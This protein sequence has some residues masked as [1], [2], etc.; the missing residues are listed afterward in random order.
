MEIFETKIKIPVYLDYKHN[1]DEF[2]D[3]INSISRRDINYIFSLDEFKMFFN[4]SGKT[5]AERYGIF[6]NRMLNT[7]SESDYFRDPREGE[8]FYY[9][10][11]MTSIVER[12][13]ELMVD[14][15]TI[16]STIL[17]ALSAKRCRILIYST[18]EAPTRNCIMQFIEYIIKKYP[19]IQKKNFVVLTNN[20]EL[21]YHDKINAVYDNTK[22][23]L[24]RIN[25]IDGITCIVHNVFM[26]VGHGDWQEISYDSEEFERSLRES[27]ALV[28][29]N[30]HRK[31]KF[32][33]LN[34]RP[35]PSRWMTALY[36]YP[37]RDTGLLS[38]TLDSGSAAPTHYEVFDESKFSD[39]KTEIAE[40]IKSNGPNEI[41]DSIRDF[42][43]WADFYLLQVMPYN[44]I[45]RTVLDDIFIEVK[46]RF[47]DSNFV[48][49]L[50]LLIDDSID[51][52]S[53]PVSDMA[54]DKFFDSYLHIVSETELGSGFGV[55]RADE[56]FWFTEKIFK[57][58]WFMQPFVLIGFPGSLS[59]LKTLGFKT[60]DEYIDERYDIEPNTHRRLIL[61]LH[62]A[63]QFYDRPHKE[64]LADYNDMMGILQHN[65]NLLLSYAKQI[66]EDIKTDIMNGLAECVWWYDN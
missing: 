39:F 15:I 13:T 53:N 2:V 60:F 11:N 46:N 29:R 35:R 28:K 65:R 5:E 24:F 49:D 58:I 12:Y 27:I 1:P 4:A 6:F 33:C 25:D 9:P 18:W 20:L 23:H 47:Q 16:P 55:P 26:T 43:V 57:P 41:K 37:D 14:Y 50:P 38:F 51:P 34:R 45:R 30:V 31:H 64:I 21:L 59:H 44:D 54:F 32:V 63:K 22:H 61:A 17:T 48:N 52:R 40:M 3:G 66:N 7:Q 19:T 42:Y 10:I 8:P 56:K 36:L 62:S